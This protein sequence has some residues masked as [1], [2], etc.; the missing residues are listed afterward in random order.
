LHFPS[1]YITHLQCSRGHTRRCQNNE[2]YFRI[3]CIFFPSKLHICIKQKRDFFQ[4]SF[5]SF[6][7][8]YPGKFFH[9]VPCTIF[10]LNQ[11]SFQH[12]VSP[13][14][15]IGNIRRNTRVCMYECV[16]SKS[17]NFLPT[18]IAHWHENIR[19][20]NTNW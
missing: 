11:K 1:T 3:G 14:D 20:N 9:L 2:K 12:K 17:S 18:I 5:L 16:L 6:Y 4:Y 19:S 8:T 13:N 7:T 15:T 10:T